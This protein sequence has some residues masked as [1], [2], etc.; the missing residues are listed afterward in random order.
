MSK[1]EPGEA[2]ARPTAQVPGNRI[3]A[4]VKLRRLG[5][6]VPM[7]TR[8][9]QFKETENEELGARGHRVPMG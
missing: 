4:E 1:A 6:G 9:T 2:R 8:V 3:A 5:E 7:L